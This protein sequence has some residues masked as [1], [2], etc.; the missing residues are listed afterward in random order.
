ME[1][2]N[3][4]SSSIIAVHGLNPKGKDD[5]LHAFETWSR[6]KGGKGDLWLRD[7][8]PITLPHARIFIAVYDSQ[9]VFGN[10]DR[11]FRQAN[12]LLEEILMKR[13]EIDDV[14]RPIV[15]LAH[16]LGGLLVKQALVNAHNNQRFSSVKEAVHGLVFFGVPHAGGNHALVQLG[17]LTTRIADHVLPDAHSRKDIM[18]TLKDGS[19]YTDI[20]KEMFRHQLEQYEIVSFYERQAKMTQIIVPYESAT[21]GLAGHREN[22]VG[23]N[24]D[25]ST[26]CSFDSSQQH[27]RD[28]YELVEFNVK[29]TCKNAIR[30]RNRGEL[31]DAQVGTET[32]LQE[33]FARLT[34][35]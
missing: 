24:A 28:L 5:D 30:A 25:H 2:P 34:E 1:Q 15:L 27:D 12:T 26:M 9:P 3:R 19:M 6:P 8:L 10:K 7:Q 35:S 18:E 32:G 17:R 21:L 22:Q 14:K 29:N 23:L 16:S 11:F 4:S 13:D 20:L 33:R 31:L